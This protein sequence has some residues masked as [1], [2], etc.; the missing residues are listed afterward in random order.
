MANPRTYGEHFKN[1][2]I[3]VSPAEH[4]HYRLMAAEHEVA[5]SDVVRLAL[6]DESLWKKAAREKVKARKATK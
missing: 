1:V 3:A 6:S 5:L 4:K 2:S